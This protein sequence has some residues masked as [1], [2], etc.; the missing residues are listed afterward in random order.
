MRFE[1]LAFDREARC[2]LEATTLGESVSGTTA[3]WEKLTQREREALFCMLDRVIEGFGENPSHARSWCITGRAEADRV[4]YELECGNGAVQ[5]WAGGVEDDDSPSW[6]QLDELLD[7]I[8]VL[9]HR[10]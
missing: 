10:A 2:I 5:G 4:Q 3:G 9:L 1:R 7:E 8:H 6:R